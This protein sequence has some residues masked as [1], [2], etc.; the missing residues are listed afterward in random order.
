MA[1]FSPQAKPLSHRYKAESMDNCR[2]LSDTPSSEAEHLVGMG[3]GT[4]V[5]SLSDL[6]LDVQ[7]RYLTCQSPGK[8]SGVPSILSSTVPTQSFRA[9]SKDWGRKGS[10]PC[11]LDCSDLEW[12]S[13]IVLLGQRKN[14]KWILVQIPQILC[15]LL[16]HFTEVSAHVISRHSL[17]QYLPLHSSPMYSLRFSPQHLNSPYSHFLICAE[18]V[19]PI[20]MKALGG[21]RAS[22]FTCLTHHCIPSIQ[23]SIWHTVDN[24]GLLNEKM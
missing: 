15:G 8:G 20:S 23:K 14:T 11:L 4:A 13:H 9:E 22:P 17:K 12:S 3:D 18:S 19:S 2:L 10:P 21:H 5:S 16:P 1:H 6:P 7:N 24:K